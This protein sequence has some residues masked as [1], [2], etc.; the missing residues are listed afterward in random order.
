MAADS[1]VLF[2]EHDEPVVLTAERYDVEKALED[3]LVKCPDLLAGAQMTPEE[4]R[5]WLLVRQQFPLRSRGGNDWSADILF[6]DQDAV[7]TVIEVKRADNRELRRMAVGQVLD[8]A[9]SLRYGTAELIRREFEQRTGSAEDWPQEL[10]DHVAGGDPEQFWA[11]VADNVADGR[12][13]IVIAADEIPPEIQAVVE[14]LNE[15]LRSAEIFALGVLQYQ[16]DGRRVLVPRLA[17]ATA[18]ARTTKSRARELGPGYH[19]V[20][21][22]AGSDAQKAASR[23]DDWAERHRVEHVDGPSSRKWVTPEGK[24]ICRLYPGARTILEVNLTGLWDT[25]RTQEA[26]R[27]FQALSALNPDRKLQGNRLPT[28]LGA[29][30]EGRWEDLEPVLTTLLEATS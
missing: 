18:A 5:R 22:Q 17:G 25:G 4:P 27:L 16:A 10:L 19:V 29:D 12:I 13:R 7:P 6:L 1:V 23:L 3:R 9:A 20:L 15:Q 2:D 28:V 21:G 14:Y 11:A 30:V 8:Y 26:E 24:T